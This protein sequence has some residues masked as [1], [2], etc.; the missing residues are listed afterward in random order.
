MF[1]TPFSAA[2]LARM[3]ASSAF[4]VMGFST[5]NGFPASTAAMAISKCTSLGVEIS[6]ASTSGQLIRS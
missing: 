5:A 3:S 1:G 6:T 2:A 4:M